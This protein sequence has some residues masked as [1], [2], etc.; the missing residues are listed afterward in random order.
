ML[1]RAL[2]FLSVAL[3][4]AFSLR[5]QTPAPA[6]LTREQAE[7]IALA[8][9]PRVRVGDLQARVQHEVVRES[10]SYRLPQ[11]TGNLTGLAANTGSR[12]AAGSLGSSRLLQHAAG[13]V[14]MAQ[15]ISDFGR[16]RSL[17]GAAQLTEKARQ[18][19]AEASREDVI[20]AADEVFFQALEAQA[21]LTVADQT[22]ATRQLLVDQVSALTAS[23]LK[24]DLDL[25]FAQ[26]NLSQAR[27]LQLDARNNV[28]SSQAALSDVLGFDK[29]TH[30][31]V[32]DDSSGSLP[33][34][35]GD[36]DKLIQDALDKRPDLQS[37]RFTIQAA[38]RFDK[39]QKDRFLP[40]IS[41]MA[42]VGGTPFGSDVYFNPRWYGA[43]GVNVSIPI[44]NGFRYSAEEKQAALQISVESER[45]RNLR[46]QIARD[47]RAAWLN[48][49]TA[50]QRV[51]VGRELLT[52]ANTALDLAQTRYQLG[53]SSIVELSQAQL[54]QAQAAIGDANARAQYG[55]ALA[56]LKFQT[57][58]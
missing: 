31:Q 7:Q 43:A 53:L 12:L 28:E 6:T 27:L 36:V 34:L 37:Q 35:P 4:A 32:I 25:S 49:N 10:R 52:Q 18:A 21:T 29:A 22:V 16:T 56:T 14:E 57:G 3:F 11:I 51:T 48:A 5:S 58:Q 9:N 30:Y 46:D 50:L 19:D 20:L 38:Q 54:Q 24:S 47:V 13:G 23:K 44:F 17:I 39:A 1:P 42:A 26:V 55:F 8:N 2:I 15:L 45:E 41:G 40:T 33:P